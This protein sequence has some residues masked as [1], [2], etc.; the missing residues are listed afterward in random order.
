MVWVPFKADPEAKTQIQVIYLEGDSRKHWLE[1]GEVRR[2][3]KEATTACD[4]HCV[5]TV[6]SWRSIPLGNSGEW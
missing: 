3:E 2:E 5:T 1:S 6:G 4:N